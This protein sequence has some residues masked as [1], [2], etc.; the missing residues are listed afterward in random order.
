MFECY[1]ICFRFV[2]S[3][4]RLAVGFI[5]GPRLL[6][7]GH[8]SFLRSGSLWVASC[9]LFMCSVFCVFSALQVLVS[10][11]WA[12]MESEELTKIW[13]SLSLND[14]DAPEVSLDSYL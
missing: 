7:F 10:C 4:I 3:G 14:K 9:L 2:S 6:P 13:E 8:F 5:K 11:C 1:S 12:V